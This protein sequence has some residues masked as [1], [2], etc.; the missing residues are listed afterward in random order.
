MAIVTPAPR[1][2]RYA[3]ATPAAPSPKRPTLRRKPRKLPT[4]TMQP[5]LINR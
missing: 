3:G 2:G 4:P 1:I 5:G